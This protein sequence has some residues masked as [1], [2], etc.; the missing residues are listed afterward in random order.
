MLE[1]WNEF[2][3]DLPTPHHRLKAEYIFITPFYTAM[4]SYNAIM[5]LKSQFGLHIL[6]VLFNWDL[7]LHP[8]IYCDHKSHSNSYFR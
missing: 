3:S 6:Q 1:E 8:F 2:E 4:D 5:P 7:I